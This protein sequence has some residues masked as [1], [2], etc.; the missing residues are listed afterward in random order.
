MLQGLGMQHREQYESDVSDREWTIIRQFL[1]QRGRL[2]RPPR[3]ERKEVF[4][5]IMYITRAGCP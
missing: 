2:G 5:A 3:Y 4:N 1:P